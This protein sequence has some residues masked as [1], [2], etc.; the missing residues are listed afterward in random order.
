MSQDRSDT[1]PNRK[2]W[3]P[4]IAVS[5]IFGLYFGVFVFLVLDDIVFRGSLL[6]RPL[7]TIS[8]NAVGMVQPVVEIV[9]F[10]LIHVGR[11][12]TWLS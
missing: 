9:Y 11:I 3:S 5:V 2:E 7:E 12:M 4:A 1:V 8:P 6:K 10:P